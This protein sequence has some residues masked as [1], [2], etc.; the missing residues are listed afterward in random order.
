MPNKWQWKLR[1]PRTALGLRPPRRER[2]ERTH[3]PQCRRRSQ[4]EECRQALCPRLRR[5]PRHHAKCWRKKSRTNAIVS[6]CCSP[7]FKR[8]G[9]TTE[10]AVD[11]FLEAKRD[12]VKP[13]GVGEGI[14]GDCPMEVPGAAGDEYPILP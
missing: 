3:R 5:Q 7:L 8:G 9:L 13:T 11:F 2:P 12:A 4:W 1:L 6:V 10:D 14:T